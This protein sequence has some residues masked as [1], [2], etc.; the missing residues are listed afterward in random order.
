M[1]YK[2]Y[3]PRRRYRRYNNG[4]R[5]PYRKS[6]TTRRAVNNLYNTRRYLNTRTGGFTGIE[7][8]FVDQ[9]RA[10][11]DLSQEWTGGEIDPTTTNCLNAVAQGTD[12]NERIGRQYTITSVLIRGEAQIRVNDNASSTRA[13]NDRCIRVALVLDKQ[14]NGSQLNAEDVFV[15]IDA[16]D[17]LYS[18]RNLEHTQRF[19]VLK[20]KVMKFNMLDADVQRGESSTLSGYRASYFK[21]IYK[22]K[23]PLV[24][25][26]SDTGA[27]V[28]DITDNSLHLI[29][30]TDAD[31]VA[32]DDEI[33][34][35]SRVRFL[36]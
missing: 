33:R 19:T 15:N 25:N 7:K 9:F 18:F 10:V 27:T 17:D 34:Y 35:F 31:D 30:T 12:Q 22:F 36:G 29:A 24:V 4:R 5:Y 23:K 20:D 32:N 1:P 16:G 14:T 11:S 28:A 3:Y 26:C 21:F 13:M 2:T 6:N 8:K